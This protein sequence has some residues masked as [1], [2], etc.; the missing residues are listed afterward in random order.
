MLLLTIYYIILHTI[1]YYA[2]PYSTLL[3]YTTANDSKPY[4]TPS[5]IDRGLCLA[6]F[7]GSEGK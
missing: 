4:S 7:A 5:D 3:Y 1:L 2:I 6:V